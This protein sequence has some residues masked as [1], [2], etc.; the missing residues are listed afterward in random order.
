MTICDDTGSDNLSFMPTSSS[1]RRRALCNIN[2]LKKRREFL[3]VAKGTFV[4]A[5]GLLLQ[6]RQRDDDE[7][8]LRVGFTCSKKVGN[9]VARNRAKRRLREVARQML[10]LYGRLGWD[11]VLIGKAKKTEERPFDEL[12]KD[13]KK[14]LCTIHEKHSSK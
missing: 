14:S 12:C 7:T 5:E 1:G 4:R 8:G 6:A 13:L 10:S 11:Y 3:F 2:I 9:A